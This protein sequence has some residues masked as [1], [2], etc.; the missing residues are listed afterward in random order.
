MN[1]KVVIFF[2]IFLSACTMAPKYKQPNL[3]ISE[4]WPEENLVVLD[5]KPLMV[6]W[7]EFFQSASLQEVIKITLENNKNLKNAVLN[8]EAA[9]A[10]Y[11]I[12]KSSVLP[13]L[14]ATVSG[15]RKHITK[16]RLKVIYF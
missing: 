6:K 14:D 7:Q 13:S 9:Q 5:Q 8:I 16:K 12:K 3:P 15:S 1:S 2:L 10:L 4:K 11:R